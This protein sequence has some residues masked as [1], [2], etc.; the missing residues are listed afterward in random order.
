M[1]LKAISL[2]YIHEALQA[3]EVG[4]DFDCCWKGEIHETLDQ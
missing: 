2:Y 4:Q 3:R 1:H